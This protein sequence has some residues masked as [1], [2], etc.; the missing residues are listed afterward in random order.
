MSRTS[1]S[2]CGAANNLWFAAREGFQI[3]GIDGSKSAISFAKRR[4]EDEN[5][6][7]DLRV[8]S[9]L[10]L[11]WE[12]DTF[13]LG[14]DRGS[15]VCVNRTNQKIAIEE[16]HRVLKSGGVF[17]SSGYSNKHTSANSGTVLEDGR[18]TDIKEGTLVG[19]GALCFHSKEQQYELFEDGWDILSISEVISTDLESG[20]PSTVHAEWRVVA[21][22]K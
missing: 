5:L 18:I 2:N 6:K 11:P 8:G 13:D 3:S 21:R 17:F 19:V 15:L 14:I 10:N 4:F 1:F 22:K 16:M 12:N 7:G 20:Q 9:L